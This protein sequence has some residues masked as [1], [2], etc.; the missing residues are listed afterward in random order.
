MN[1]TLED[2]EKELLK[3]TNQYNGTNTTN[4]LKSTETRETPKLKYYDKSEQKR[5]K[6]K[7]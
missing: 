5:E 7:I 3:I 2:R 4:W 1:Q 6:S